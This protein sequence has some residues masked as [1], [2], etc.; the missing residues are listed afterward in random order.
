MIS[1]ALIY[2]VQDYQ[3]SSKLLF[4]Y[5]PYGKYTLVAKGVKNYKNNFFH[6]ADYLNLIE[7]DLNINKSIQTLKR[8]KLLNSYDSLKNNYKNFKIASKILNIVDKLIVNI[9]NEDKV[10]LLLLKL[11]DYNNISLAYLSFLVKITYALGYRLSF[12]KEDIKGFNLQLG[13]TISKNEDINIDLNVLETLYL[14]LI[15]FS[16]EEP[17]IEDEYIYLIFDF[18]KRYYLHHLD[19]NIEKI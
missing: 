8:G 3:E 7:I 4:V 16:K 14:K 5:T 17:I 12:T 11:L 2:K 6:L 1:Q 10:F 15:Y 19:Y 13:R 18:I 9:N